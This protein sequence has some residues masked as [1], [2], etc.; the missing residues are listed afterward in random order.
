MLATLD[1]HTGFTEQIADLPVAIHAKGHD[2][3]SRPDPSNR[4]AFQHIGVENRHGP[5]VGEA[6]ATPN[7]PFERDFE[8]SLGILRNPGSP[9]GLGGAAPGARRRTCSADSA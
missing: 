8:R 3:V 9:D 4:R 2:P 5:T 6:T 1:R 7:A